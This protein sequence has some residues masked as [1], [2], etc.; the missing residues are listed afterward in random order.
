MRD[1]TGS[2]RRRRGRPDGAAEPAGRLRD[3]L[4]A[5]RD[6]VVVL[7]GEWR[8]T[9]ATP[10]VE[11][12]LGRPPG[13][14]AGRD[15]REL[16]PGVAG[17]E[18]WTALEGALGSGAV[19]ET[20]VDTGPGGRRTRVVAHPS[21][22]GLSVH[23]Y[24]APTGDERFRD[25]P[26]HAP[27]GMALVELD[28]RI[29]RANPALCALA[30]RS[31]EELRG[32]TL[33][34]LAHPEDLPAGIRAMRRLAAGELPV[35]ELEARCLRRDGSVA[36]VQLAAS[37]V[38]DP[39][40]APSYL[41]VQARDVTGRTRAR[42][43]ERVLAEAGRGLGASLD[44]GETLR[45]AAR[46]LVPRLGDWCV[47][48]LAD[49]EG[50]VRVA[51]V[52]APS[53]DDEMLLRM[54]L[55]RLRRELPAERHP[56]QR[57]LRTGR[58]LLLSGVRGDPDPERGDDRLLARLRAGEVM[59][60]PLAGRDGVLGCLSVGTGEGR[61]E[62]GAPDLE[63]LEEVAART[64]LAL[65][66]ARLYRDAR[67]AARLR[68]EVLGFVAHDLRSPVS[69]ISNLA[70]GLLDGRFTEEER[71]R[72]L[73]VIVNSTEQVGRLLHD[74][75]DVSRME[76]GRL[77]VRPEPLQ[78]DRALGRAAELLDA[79]ARGRGVHLAVECEPRLPPVLADH[80]RLVQVLCNLVDNALASMP[81]GGRVTVSAHARDGEVAIAVAD[82]G[83]GI[84]EDEMPYVFDHI[85][86]AHA[87]RAAGAGLGLTIARA[88]VEAHG[89]LLR[90][91]SRVGEGTTFSFALPLAP[92]TTPPPREEEP[93]PEA[94]PEPPIRVML[95]D[96]DAMVIRGLR[97]MLGR[98]PCIDI[99]GTA[100]TGEEALELAESLHPDVVVMDLSMPG[101]GG[102]E[103]T[104]RVVQLG[105]GIHVLAFCGDEREETVR[106]SLGAGATGLLS[107]G[108][109]AEELLPAVRAAAAG[110]VVLD[111]GMRRLLADR[112][113]G[114]A[115]PS[116]A[117]SP[118]VPELSPQ[119][120][121]ILALSAY[122][123]TSAEIARK[124]YFSPQTVSS[125]R[126]RAM[127]RLGLKSKA[128]L[129]RFALQRRLLRPD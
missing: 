30:G 12:A 99:V 102:I 10:S 81:S 92:A 77:D 98:H 35:L 129:V 51:E 59:I 44:A 104:R 105:A 88:L 84:P 79:R 97:E 20:E 112:A 100:A 63:L 89:G 37:L 13:G 74:L 47:V 83:Q 11:A 41:V 113:R 5:A 117:P 33:Q 22:P 103:A 78:P 110:T 17:S 43:R 121:K 54:V 124:L 29:A 52:A 19:L 101:I 90:V 70:A 1:G 26:E 123:Y 27:V 73:Q 85:R 67:E 49:G 93:A 115:P 14:I 6:G 57:V 9:F 76:E 24:D 116:P 34:Q 65:E 111:A 61:G 28:G 119:E 72:F 53:P 31:G 107:K 23:F 71:Q 48:E 15:V 25:A 45:C 64:A 56:V 32:L 66:N 46:L 106:E 128:Q 16:V 39:G 109:A 3:V 60:A 2:D 38:R 21:A 127:R 122:G 82:T 94:A 18:L 42:E 118:P 87:R 120:E 7:D 80:D 86:Q 8:V 55:A 62:Y 96:D 75:L 126:A 40:G 91:E 108:S 50:R 69:A 36:W 68:D 4:A 125:Y 95:V 58:A 114:A